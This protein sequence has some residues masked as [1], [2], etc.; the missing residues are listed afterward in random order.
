[1]DLREPVPT[2]RFDQP[3]DLIEAFAD[4]LNA[5]DA[6]SLGRLFSE[7]AEFV[8]VRGTCMHGREG[9]IEGHA[10]SFSGP[11]AGSTFQF[12]SISELPVTAEVTVVHAHCIRDRLPDAPPDHGARSLDRSPACRSSGS[13]WMAGGGRQ[14][15]AR[16][17]SGW[18]VLKLT[19]GDSGGSPV[20]GSWAYRTTLVNT[21]LRHDRKRYRRRVCWARRVSARAK[22][23]RGARRS[24]SGCVPP[25]SS[26]EV[27]GFWISDL[28]RCDGA[29]TRNKMP[30]R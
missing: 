2:A 14:Q 1:M 20:V 30:H 27:R 19:D 15:C 7:G 24:W 5:K 11:L 13:R 9:I 18:T 12:H 22:I 17:A 23:A 10:L 26:G 25:H 21:A 4:A 29:S 6:E 28:R 8:N 3:R 16:D